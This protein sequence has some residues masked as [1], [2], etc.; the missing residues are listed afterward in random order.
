MG[1]VTDYIDC[2]RCGNEAHNEYYYSTGEEHIICLHCG[3]S[4]HFHLE[5]DAINPQNFKIE[6]FEPHGTY[7]IRHKG[8]LNHE[9]G[10]FTNADS[11][12]EF[13]K[14]YS[15]RKGDLVSAVYT[16]FKDGVLERIVLMEESESENN[17]SDIQV[18][19]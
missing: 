17:D 16:T 1:S 18:V 19:T 4:R 14:V 10:A 8:T 7:M 2:P 5:G 3:Y 12:N 13:L 9:C 15:E 11:V 6:E